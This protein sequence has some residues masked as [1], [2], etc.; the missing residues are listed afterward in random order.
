M[1]IFQDSLEGLLKK[2]AD[3]PDIVLK[4]QLDDLKR[5]AIQQE[6]SQ[7]KV[8]ICI[9]YVILDIYVSAICKQFTMV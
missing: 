4:S 2:F 1:Q 6:L 8:C 7:T 3:V 5:E 9:N